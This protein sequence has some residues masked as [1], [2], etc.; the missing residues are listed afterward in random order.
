[1]SRLFVL[2]VSLSWLRGGGFL[3]ALLAI[4]LQD[5]LEPERNKQSPF[6]EGVE[7][8][9]GSF[10]KTWGVCSSPHRNAVLCSPSWL[11]RCGPGFC[12]LHLCPRPGPSQSR[13]AQGIRGAPR[14]GG[15]PPT[16]L[17][18]PGR[19]SVVALGRPCDCD[20]EA[21]LGFVFVAWGGE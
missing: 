16:A 17:A 1:M 10:L 4:S 2:P 18:L 9:S 8:V 5:R 20:L 13:Q 6:R 19:K 14:G 15:A 11:Q 3:P 7:R 12:P 21:H